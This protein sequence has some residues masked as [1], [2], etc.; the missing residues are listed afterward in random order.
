MLAHIQSNTSTSTRTISFAI[1]TDFVLWLLQE[2]P[3]YLG[4]SLGCRLVLSRRHR[5]GGLKA[6]WW[7]VQQLPQTPTTCCMGANVV[8]RHAGESM[9]CHLSLPHRHLSATSRLTTQ[10]GHR[11]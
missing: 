10:N 1:R 7:S 8:A 6:G 4:V 9:P 11:Y 2:F 5:G 3:E